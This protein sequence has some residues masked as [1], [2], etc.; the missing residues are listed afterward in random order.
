MGIAVKNQRNRHKKTT[1]EVLYSTVR[2]IT[3]LLVSKELT[4]NGLTGVRIEEAMR[5]EGRRSSSV[6]VTG[7]LCRWAPG[8]SAISQIVGKLSVVIAGKEIYDDD[9]LYL[10]TI[11]LV[12]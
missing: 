12:L 4:T 11:L 1:R 3:D 9:G 5:Y 7:F 10:V 6:I 2:M 8:G